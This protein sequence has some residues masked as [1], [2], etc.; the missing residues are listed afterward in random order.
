MT[1]N[2]DL[3]NLGDNTSKLEQQGLVQIVASSITKGASGSASVDSK[4]TVTF[5]G[6][7]SISL[8]SIFSSTYK[9]YLFL[10]TGTTSSTAAQ[11][12]LRLRVSNTDATTGYN[13]AGFYWGTSA[14]AYTRI[15]NDSGTYIV[16]VDDVGAS[17]KNFETTVCSPFLTQSTQ[18]FSYGNA[19][20]VVPFLATGQLDNSISYTSASWL[21]S[22]G[23]MTGQIQVFGYNQ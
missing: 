2:R 3:A 17:D 23:T 18:T 19:A 15:V 5:T 14:V 10:F 8:N 4:G 7:E 12:L 20:T 22:T 21:L 11:V 6:T 9:N 1:R 13:Q 16:V